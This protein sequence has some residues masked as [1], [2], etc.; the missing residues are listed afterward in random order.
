LML[1]LLTIERI[2]VVNHFKIQKP[3]LTDKFG[4]NCEKIPVRLLA[5]V[6]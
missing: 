2:N 1:K 6:F 4:L 3:S 5:F